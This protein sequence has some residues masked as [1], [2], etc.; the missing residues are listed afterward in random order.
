MEIQKKSVED[1]NQLLKDLIVGLENMSDNLQMIQ[2]EMDFQPNQE[3]EEEFHDLQE[4]LQQEAPFF[5]LASEGPK[6]VKISGPEDPSTLLAQREN[7]CPMGGL[8]GIPAASIAQGSIGRPPIA[9]RCLCAI[10]A[11]DVF[12]CLLPLFVGLRN[13][14]TETNPH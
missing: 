8:E 9:A 11:Q 14:N 5:V 1:T 3:A 7:L 12:Q 6:T 2:K 4:E 13:T 10:C